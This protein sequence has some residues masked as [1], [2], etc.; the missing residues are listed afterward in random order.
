MKLVN[1]RGGIVKFRIPDT[2]E[3][4][5]EDEGG[6]T[7]YDDTDDSGILRLNILTFRSKSQLGANAAVESLQDEARSYS[8]EVEA[9][10]DQNSAIISY[11]Q[12]SRDDGEDLVIYYWHI[13]NIV[14]PYHCRIA[15]FS[16]CILAQREHEPAMIKE[17]AMLNKSL[18]E[19]V[20]SE[21]L[22][23]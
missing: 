4:E 12:T 14:P 17:L 19:C 18:R 8:T 10:P 6:G 23:E 2:W 21:E 3:E 13:A 1:Y 22:G 20:F 5:Y 16:Y 15:I 7:F 9:L 11:R